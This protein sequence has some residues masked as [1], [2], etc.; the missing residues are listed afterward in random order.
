MKK[1]LKQIVAAALCAVLLAALWG[2]EIPQPGFADF[3]VSGY[4]QALLDSSYLDVHGPFMNISGANQEDAEANHAATAENAAVRFCNHY[5]V[6]PDDAQM[7]QLEEIMG[8]AYTQ[9]R[10]TVL[11]EVRTGSGYDVTVQITS[12]LNF[13]GCGKDIE[14]MREN[15]QAE[16]SR[17]FTSSAGTEKTASDLNVNSIFADKVIAFCDLQMNNV[18][19]SPEQRTVTLKILQ[20]DNGELQLDINQID[21]IDQT[22]LPLDE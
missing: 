6:A 13:A 8:R 3:D 10:Y 16:A 7:D 19:Y 4:I 21:T 18:Q 20:T 9:A 12:I 1:T 11:D 17:Q 5:Q 2:C 22:V 14:Q 15:A